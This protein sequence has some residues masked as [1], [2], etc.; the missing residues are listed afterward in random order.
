MSRSSSIWIV[1]DAAQEL[2][3]GFTVRHE[4]ITWLKKQDTLTGWLA[5]RIP[6]NPGSYRAD[7]RYSR[8][9]AQDLIA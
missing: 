6:D 3:A 9:P 2:T 7:H 4:M 5:V 1:L 8:V